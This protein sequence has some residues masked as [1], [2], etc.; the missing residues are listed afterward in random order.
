[1]KTHP[2]ATVMEDVEITICLVVPIRRALYHGRTLWLFSFS[3]LETIILT[4]T[5][6]GVANALAAPL[7]GI[8]LSPTQMISVTWRLLWVFLWVWANYLPFAINNQRGAQSVAEDAINKPWRPLPQGRMSQ[9]E[10]KRLMLSLYLATPCVSVAVHGGLRQNITLILLGTW[11]NNLGGADGHP[12]IRNAINALGYVCFTSG[13]MEA[14]LAAPLSFL[15]A[16]NVSRLSRWFFMLAGVE[17]TTV[18]TQD[19]YDKE[20][21]AARGRQ[22]LPLVIG[23]GAARWTIAFWMLL[24]G[25]LC[26]AFWH[27]PFAYFGLGL[28][29]AVLI[30][31]RTLLY[32]TVSSDKA[33]FVFGNV[34]ISL[35]YI[36]PLIS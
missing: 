25:A 6:F 28:G 34:W 33:T 19:M 13:A 3:D 23:D 31:T 17:L 14:A 5:I 8:S 27:V 1:M 29:L 15:H 22:T 26:P 12:F 7:Y 20:G 36:N 35:L 21:D 9:E 4:S 30:G 32:R 24:W 16:G 2:S 18:H 10:A 11:Y